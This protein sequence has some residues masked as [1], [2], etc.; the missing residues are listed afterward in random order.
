MDLILK[1]LYDRFQD[2]P[3]FSKTYSDAILG[4][5]VSETSL[6]DGTINSLNLLNECKLDLGGELFHSYVERP[7]VTLYWALSNNVDLSGLEAL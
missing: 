3:K 2:D 5:R 6:S 1:N 7:Y 4:A